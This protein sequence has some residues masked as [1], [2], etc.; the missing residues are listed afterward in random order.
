MVKTMR[1]IMAMVS[2]RTISRECSYGGVLFVFKHHRVGDIQRSVTTK[3]PSFYSDKYRV[4]GFSW[5]RG[6]NML[7][8]NIAGWQRREEAQSAPVLGIL[9]KNY[10]RGAQQSLSYRLAPY[11]HKLRHLFPSLMARTLDGVC[12]MRRGNLRQRRRST[13]VDGRRYP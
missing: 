12:I 11:A 1:S 6:N 13:L 4:A 9:V 5:R 8:A 10:G 7:S 3:T 2:R